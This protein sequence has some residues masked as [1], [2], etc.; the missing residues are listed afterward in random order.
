MKILSARVVIAGYRTELLT[1]G[2]GGE[3]GIFKRDTRQIFLK[4]SA[5]IKDLQDPAIY[6]VVFHIYPIQ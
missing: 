4:D 6:T 1:G 5:K 2:G 3:G